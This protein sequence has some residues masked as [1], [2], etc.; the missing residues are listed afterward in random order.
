MAIPNTTSID[1]CDGPQYIMHGFFFSP[2]SILSLPAA[3][4]FMNKPKAK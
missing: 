3:F 1:L 2:N 4:N